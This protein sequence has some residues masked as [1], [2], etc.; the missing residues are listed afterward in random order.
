MKNKT[1]SQIDSEHLLVYSC[2]KIH[3]K[4]RIQ[5][6]TCLLKLWCSVRIPYCT[7]YIVQST[8][9]VHYKIYAYLVFFSFR[10]GGIC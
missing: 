5:K 9:T 1:I 4:S 6:K 8:S 2:K 10:K 7:M 3:K